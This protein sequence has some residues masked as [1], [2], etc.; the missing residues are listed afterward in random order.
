MQQFEQDVGTRCDW[1][2]IDHYNTD[3]P[4]VDLLIQGVNEIRKAL[5]IDQTILKQANIVTSEFV[6][7]A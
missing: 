7:A 3:H 6:V 2:A 5:E 4:H 1:V